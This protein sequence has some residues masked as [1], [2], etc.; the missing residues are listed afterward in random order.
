MN[1]TSADIF[2]YILTGVISCLLGGGIVHSLMTLIQ[3]RPAAVKSRIDAKKKEALKYFRWW[4]SDFKDHPESYEIHTCVDEHSYLNYDLVYYT[5]FLVK[6]TP[7]YESW[8]KDLEDSKMLHKRAMKHS[9]M[10]DAKRADT[11]I[12][13]FT[14]KIQ[15]HILYFRNIANDPRNPLNPMYGAK[16]VDFKIAVLKD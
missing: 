5:I 13:E 8:K 3:S 1:L 11:F 12:R 10:D 9:N 14:N 4:N 2:A 7:E 6:K 15:D 16:F